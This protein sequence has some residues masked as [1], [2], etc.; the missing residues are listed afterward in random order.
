M[1]AN[2]SKP[3][4]FFCVNLWCQ[5]YFRNLFIKVYHWMRKKTKVIMVA[6][7]EDNA[8]NRPRKMFDLK[9]FKDPCGSLARP[10]FR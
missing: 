1:S 3:S 5:G 6:F 2:A 7:A 4:K 10:M 9:N 8:S